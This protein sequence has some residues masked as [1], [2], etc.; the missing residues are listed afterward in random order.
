MLQSAVALV[1]IAVVAVADI[2]PMSMFTWLSTI[3]AVVV[4]VLLTACSAAAFGFFYRNPG[5]DWGSWV[6]FWAPVLGVVGG[7]GVLVVM[8]A[9]GD[10]LLQV[11]AGSVLTY[12]PAAV[13]GVAAVV[14]A[15]WG[16]RLR[17]TSPGVFHGI[18]RGRP[19]PMAQLD[20]GM[21]AV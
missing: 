13:V 15:W 21:P 9:Y 5:L 6:G 2:S 18:G 8:V 17:W 10:A 16:L 11:P 20:H 12:L 1:V 3:A 19:H 7:S 4:L 14:G